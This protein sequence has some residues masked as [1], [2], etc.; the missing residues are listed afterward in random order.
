MESESKT[1]NRLSESKTQNRLFGWF[2]NRNAQE[3][4]Q[5]AYGNNSESSTHQSSFLPMKE[6]GAI[7][8][9]PVPCI[10]LD[11][12][13]NTINAKSPRMKEFGEMLNE[14]VKSI[15]IPSTSIRNSP[16]NI[17]QKT[18][19][20]S[21]PSQTKSTGDEI[22]P[23]N[24]EI[25]KS[26]NIP[27]NAKP[28]SFK[29]KKKKNADDGAASKKTK[30]K[31]N[32]ENNESGATKKKD[33]KNSSSRNVNASDG[34]GTTK[35]KEPKP[36]ESS[37]APL[38]SSSPKNNHKLT[39]EE[40]VR[41]KARLKARKEA[42]LKAG[43]EAAKEEVDRL[44]GKE[45]ARRSN[46]AAPPKQQGW[47]EFGPRSSKNSSQKHHQQQQRPGLLSGLV[48]KRKTA[49]LKKE[50]KQWQQKTTECN[51]M[52]VVPASTRHLDC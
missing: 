32:P 23:P 36:P 15:E 29:K 13:K 47:K 1:Q 10:T 25:K 6:F 48:E 14:P 45:E 21:S 39:A 11:S 20:H 33:T 41:L 24:S 50:T 30:K 7:L 4:K 49:H 9:D 42:R 19:K 3:G 34:G 8:K 22:I 40:E 5:P 12:S 51:L 28:K 44:K 38:P 26:D 52:G 16:L 46:P 31:Q 43:K 2:Q 35:K 37:E 18:T 27:N 17:N